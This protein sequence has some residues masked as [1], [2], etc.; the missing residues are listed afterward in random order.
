MSQGA[1]RLATAV[2][3]TWAG[4]HALALVRG[5]SPAGPLPWRMFSEPLEFVP[6]I[7][8]E[9]VTREGAAVEVPLRELF[10]FTRGATDLR[11]YDTSAILSEPGHAAERKALARWLA[12]QMELRGTPL[13]TVRVVR[14]T[15]DLRSGEARA[16]VLVRVE[17]EDGG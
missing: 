17:V 4:I 9:G 2:I 11:A 7:V 15:R 5:L 1:R 14:R 6:T 3:A 12:R 16:R 10:R 13:R 8:A